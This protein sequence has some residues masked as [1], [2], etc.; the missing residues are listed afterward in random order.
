MRGPLFS[1]VIPEARI[2]ARQQ[3]RKTCW[4]VNGALF[5]TARWQRLPKLGLID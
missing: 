4:V 2:P 1:D 3:L 5:V